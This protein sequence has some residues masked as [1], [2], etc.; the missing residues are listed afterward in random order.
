MKKD[1]T[2]IKLDSTDHKILHILQ[3][4]SDLTVKEISEKVS[5]SST[6]VH[7]RI[8]R[9]EESGVIK[10]YVA[11]VDPVKAGKG[12]IVFVNIKMREHNIEKREELIA[13][14]QTFIQVIELHHTTGNYDFIAKVRVG[15]IDEYR[16]FLVNKLASIDSIL[17]MA[18]YIVLD[19]PKLTTSIKFS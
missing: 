15:S 19:S 12:L 5:L 6:P 18:S 1:T 8:K 17:D 9:L 10:S 7:K 2:E 16:N 14:I 4:N 3:E 13:N 11:L